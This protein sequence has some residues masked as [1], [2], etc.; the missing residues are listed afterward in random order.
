MK[1]VLTCTQGVSCLISSLV[2]LSIVSSHA[3]VQSG[4]VFI[5]AVSGDTTYSSNDKWQA[6]KENTVLK[7]GTILKTGSNSTIDLILQ[8]N[9]TVLRLTPDSMLALDKLNKESA[10]EEVITETSL[11][12]LTGSLVGSQRKLAS[13][14]TFTI[15]V[16]GGTVTIKGTE[17]VVRADGAVSTLSGEVHV[18][19]NLPGNKGS[20]QVD[21]P[22][23]S[24]FN[25]ATGQ[26]VTTTSA[27]LQN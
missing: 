16:A 15:N 14:S 10:G 25:P 7:G 19:Y 9:G 11:K 2:A 5:K 13:P 1:Y 24:S 8:Y 4:Q 6:L 3:Q 18:I 20:V 27:Y 12:L 17:Y 26:V 22:A 23:G 21:I